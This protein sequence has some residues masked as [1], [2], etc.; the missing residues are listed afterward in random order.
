M[1]GYTQVNKAEYIEIS[2]SLKFFRQNDR[3]WF[4]FYVVRGI[5]NAG[6]PLLGKVVILHG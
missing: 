5:F 3:E 1:N 6:F 4:V 2:Y